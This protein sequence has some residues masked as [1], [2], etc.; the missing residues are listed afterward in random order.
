MQQAKG[1]KIYDLRCSDKDTLPGP[2]VGLSIYTDTT[3]PVSISPPVGAR[4]ATFYVM[5]GGG[6]GGGA[7][8]TVTVNGNIVYSG[9][10]GGGGSGSLVVETRSF[11]TTNQEILKL[12]VGAGGAAGGVDAN[13]NPTNGVPGT[14]SSI[15]FETGGVRSYFINTDGGSGGQAPTAGRL[16]GGNVQG[17]NGGGGAFGGGGGGGGKGTLDGDDNYGPGGDGGASD[18]SFANRQ[19]GKNGFARSDG[20]D[21]GA[22]FPY[23]PSTAGLPG[24]TQFGGGGTGGGS[25]SPFTE[26]PYG[27]GGDGAT[28]GP[29]G[30]TSA[31]PGTA[32]AIVIEWYGALN[33]TSAQGALTHPASLLF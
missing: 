8:N 17:G 11:S 23:N 31:Q 6:G 12:E 13:G 7:G 22:G 9:G 14:A 24:T 3:N 29:N 19:S 1:L 10:G 15:D 28:G 32:G 18:S 4:A 2:I 26:N 5:G 16:S 27:K 25:V 21:G 20:G 30:A 33:S